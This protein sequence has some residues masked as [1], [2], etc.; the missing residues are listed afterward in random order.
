MGSDDVTSLRIAWLLVFVRPPTLLTEQDESEN[1]FV[2]VL[3]RKGE[4]TF[5][6]ILDKELILIP[7]AVF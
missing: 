3:R 5:S 2:S 7:G 6:H 1:G 4:E